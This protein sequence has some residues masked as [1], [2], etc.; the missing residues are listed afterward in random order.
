MVVIAN[1]F[2]LQI[3]NFSN[4]PAGNGPND[5]FVVG[6][7]ASTDLLS[8]SI[9]DD[10]TTLDGDTIVGE[11]ADDANQIAT[12]TN[13]SGTIIHTDA[14]YVELTATYSS[15]GQAD[16]TVWRF[17]LDNGFRFWAMSSIPV[18]GV[19][20]STTNLQ[21]ATVTGLDPSTLPQI[22]CFT[23][24]VQIETPTRPVLIENLSV[25]KII[26]SQ[27]GVPCEIYWIGSRFITHTQLSANPKLRPVRITAGSLG[28]GLPERD[29]LVSRQHRML[30]SSK[31]AKR[32]FG[33]AEVLVPAIKLTALPGIYVDET[34][35]EVEY[36]HIL[37]RTMRLS[38]QREQRPK[39]C[40]PGQA[41]LRLCHLKPAKRS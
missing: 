36:F 17:E 29:L 14:C 19:T 21:N 39:A 22:P 23:R 25:G 11:T 33:S 32:M 15:P 20:Y 5:T 9:D 6:S 4:R 31:I 37:L 28:H 16:V 1:F 12:I 41:L 24:G 7:F 3:A 30:I 8:V 40:T 27:S 34:V 18:V 26:L 38:M 10:D 2:A 35:T 13:S